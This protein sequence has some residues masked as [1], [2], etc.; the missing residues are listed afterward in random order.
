M[1]QITKSNIAVVKNMFRLPVFLA[2]ERHE[3]KPEK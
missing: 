2:R 3:E 1:F